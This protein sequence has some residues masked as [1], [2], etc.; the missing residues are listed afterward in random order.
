M[1]IK[2]FGFCLHRRAFLDSLALRYGWSLSNTPLTCACGTSFSVNHALSCSKGGFPL[3]RHNEIRDLT[4]QLL[5]EVC[6]NV[7]L[8]PD[9]Q[10]VHEN[11]SLGASVNSTDG[12]RLDIAVNGFWRG[13]I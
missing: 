11:V 2:E 12:A 1:P 4:A 3:I 7:R 5:T 10:P 8:E 13:Q 9:L 6:N